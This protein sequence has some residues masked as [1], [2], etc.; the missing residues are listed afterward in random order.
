M[1][2]TKCG[3]D[4][5]SI[6]FYH[7]RRVCKPCMISRARFWAENNKDRARDLHTKWYSEHRDG[8]IRYQR[9]YKKRV[10]K[11]PERIYKAKHRANHPDRARARNIITWELRKGKLRPEPCFVCGEPKTHAHHPDY[12]K[13]RDVIWLCTKHHLEIHGKRVGA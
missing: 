5:L 4:K 2:C 10:G 3:S 6:D 12:S 9:E 13:P 1:I 11:G 7:N 8:V